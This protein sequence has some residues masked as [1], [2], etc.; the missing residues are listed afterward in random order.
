MIRNY[1]VIAIRSMMRNKRYSFINILGLSVGVAC[2]LLL[3]L[4]VQD[5]LSFDQHHKDGDRIFRITTT[6]SAIQDGRPWERTSPPIAWGI[7]DEVPEIENVTRI[8]NP[9][10]AALNLIRYEDEKFYEP[11][12]YLAD[13]T[14]FEFLTYTFVE[15]DYRTALSEPNSVV[16]TTQMAK[17]L[18]QG[19]SALDKVINVTQGGTPND[20]R[21]TGVILDDKNSYVNATFFTSMS[22]RGWADYVRRPDV[23]DEWAGNNFMESFIKLT[24]GYSLDGVVKK[25]NE[26]FVEHAAEDM[27][28]LGFTKTL[29]LEPLTEIYL[30]GV[31]SQSPRIT[32]LYVVGSIA[33]FILLIAC[34]NF[35]NLSTAKAAQRANEVGLRKTLGAY[36]SSLMVQFLGEALVIVAIAIVLSCVIIQLALPAFNQV[37]TKNISLESANVYFIVLALIGITVV[38]GVIAGSYPAFYLSSFQPANVLKG[39]SLLHSSNSVLRKSLVVFQFVIAITLVCGMFAVTRQLRFMQEQDLG[40]SPMHKL[41][42]PLR[43]PTAQKNYTAISSEL[44]KLG[45]VKAVTGT[46]YV[47]GEIVFSD[48]G[49]YP[50]GGSMDKATLI[51]NNVVEPNYLKTM[52]I[53]LIAGS[54]FPETKYKDSDRRLILNREAATQLGFKPED[55]VGENLYFE[56]QGERYEFRV[57]GVMENY[58]QQSLKEKIYPLLFRVEEEPNY[59]FMVVELESADFTSTLASI[60]ETWKTMNN[61][62]PFEYSFL[63]DNIQKQY[64]EDRK[65]GMVIS[66]FTIIAMIISCLG[67]YGLSTYMA[68]RR[69]KEIGVRKV[70]GASVRQ[71]VTMINSE[72]TKLV[73]VAFVI[74][75]PLA[76]YSIHT[77]L[78]SFAYKAPISVVIFIVAGIAALLIALITVSF[79]SIKAATQ[80][81]ANALRNE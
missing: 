38:T 56:W 61:D 76:W 75:I 29:G 51:R 7:K 77:W 57:I 26:V 34:I 42:F 30:Y 62:T 27:K 13:S 11:N 10:G 74:S 50:K 60:E 22:S 64:E 9:P 49:L 8:F 41:V 54:N 65:A 48:F 3:A 78:E 1:I 71:I 21:I 81:P 20:F 16:I 28:A 52:G 67:L 66:T 25:V 23:K 33:V 47:P 19:E 36:R 68:E 31:T 4:Y 2:C 79:E 59:D 58:N 40:F 37:T 63:D 18:F 15:G 14:V 35:M 43:T 53:P 46:A 6:T 72:F 12:G 80:N 73:A 32:Y 17:K 70:M 55:I 39:K 45:H 5:E 69:F 44:S 24:P